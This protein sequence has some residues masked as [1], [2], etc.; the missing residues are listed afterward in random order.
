MLLPPFE[1]DTGRRPLAGRPGVRPV[2]ARPPRPADSRPPRPDVRASRPADDDV[3]RPRPMVPPVPAG[4]RTTMA[5]FQAVPAPEAQPDRYSPASLAAGRP[6]RDPD[7]AELDARALQAEADVEDTASSTSPGKRSPRPPVPPRDGAERPPRDGD[8]RRA[9]WSTG[10]DVRIGQIS[11][12][13]PPSATYGDWT[14][15]SRDQSERTRSS[16]PVPGPEELLAPGSRGP[17]RA[18]ETTAIPERNTGDRRGGRP[19]SGEPEPAA[20]VPASDERASDARASE[21]SSSR[22]SGSGPTRVVGNRAALRAQ[23]QAAEVERRKAARQTGD[24]E[25]N[26][27]PKGGKGRGSG[28]RMAMI[29]VAAAVVALGVLGVYSFTSPHT[30][31]AAHTA[32]AGTSATTTPVAAPTETLPPVV[33]DAQQ[34]L[35]SSAAAP[36]K[37]PITVLNATN[38]NGLAAK[39]SAAFGAGGWQTSGVGAYTGGDVAATTVFFTQGDENQRQAAI[40]LVNQF[41]QLSGPAPR[42][43][44]VPGNAKPGLVV[45]AAGEWRP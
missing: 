40:A 17:G 27:A 25:G 44:D 30:K 32:A 21:K 19:D 37:A 10:P 9:P 4:P 36:V 1:D 29:L 2:D 13:P 42:F 5:P 28:R 14:K 20:P 35:A 11:P 31:V 8:E 18:P 24:R 41:P 34:P 38:V 15:P 7:G 16:A 43:F 39:I 6:P 3:V 23:R 22:S 45:V 26:G 12:P 33:T